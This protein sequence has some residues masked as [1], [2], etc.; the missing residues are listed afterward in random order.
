[1]RPARERAGDAGGDGRDA[2][3]CRF[4]LWLSPTHTLRGIARFY[5]RSIRPEFQLY[6]TPINFDP[7]APALPIS[8]PNAFAAEL[9][10][11]RPAD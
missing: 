2:G 10:G 1:M 9:A 8:T 11:A 3:L 5:L 4:A 7:A 6:V